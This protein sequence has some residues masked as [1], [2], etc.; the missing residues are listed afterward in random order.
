[1]FDTTRLNHLPRETSRAAIACSAG[2]AYAPR[3]MI[4]SAD[5]AIDDDF[6]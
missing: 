5:T 3:P 2:G 1:M 4:A 6:S